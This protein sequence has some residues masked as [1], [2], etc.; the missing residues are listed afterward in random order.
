MKKFVF[1]LYILASILFLS[2]P[3]SAD[4]PI[5]STDFHTAYLDLEIVKKAAEQGLIDNE[6]ANYLASS[7]N[8]IDT[9]AAVINALGWDYDG[10]NN[11]EKYASIIYNKSIKNIDMESLN[12]Q[13]LFNLGYLMAMDNYFDTTTS[14]SILQK[15]NEKISNSFTVSMVNAIVY[16]QQIMDEDIWVIANK[17][18]KNKE[19]K[20][21]L[22]PEAAKIIVDYMSLYSNEPVLNPYI[23]KNVI[24]MQIGNP[25][26]EV[27]DNTFELDFGRGTK[28]E[29]KNNRTFLPIGPLITAMGGR[30]SWDGSLQK[31]TIEL[32]SKK[33]EL[34]IGKK[35]AIVNGVTKQIDVAPYTSNSRTML[36]LRF[37]SENLDLS[38]NWNITNKEITLT[39]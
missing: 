26:I 2:T 34:W 8:P 23:N 12:G 27:N 4:S 37:I 35:T 38:I 11:A 1:I 18:I 28:P 30:T 19:L 21:D 22:R 36:P 10:R 3:V 6:I 7:N 14:S 15:A 31:V 25:M 9:K 32:N 17:V 16:S 29:L 33:V 5:T 20:Q 24:V 13:E 39:I